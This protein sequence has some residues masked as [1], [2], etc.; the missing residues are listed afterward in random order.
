MRSLYTTQADTWTLV[1]PTLLQGIP[2]ALFF[3]PLT[4]IILSG[5]SPDKI[6][7]AAGLSNFVRVFFGA[8]GTAIA[9]TAW[10]D[11]NILH[12]SRLM[13]QA[14]PLNPAFNESIAL[15]RNSFGMTLEQAQAR[16]EQTLNSQ[17]TMLG[18]ND[19]FWISAVIFVAIIPLIWITKPA[20]G[21]S[22]A[23]AAAAAH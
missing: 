22:S 13:E 19:I 1:L 23:A 17:A 2:T 12:H 16:F 8:A 11:R 7:A 5:L 14:S 9:S 18:I 6:P 21:G 20:S 3:V 15:L 4:A 10:S